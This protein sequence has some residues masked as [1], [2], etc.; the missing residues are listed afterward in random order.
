MQLSSFVR[1]IL[2]GSEESFKHATSEAKLCF[3]EILRLCLRPVL[4]PLAG[5]SKE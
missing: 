5:M 1:V 2:R 3:M 4:I